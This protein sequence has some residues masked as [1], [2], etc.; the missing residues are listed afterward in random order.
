MVTLYQ[1]SADRD[2]QPLVVS[3][4]TLIRNWPREIQP[5]VVSMVTLGAEIV[6][7]QT[8]KFLQHFV[9]KGK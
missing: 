7:L 8:T 2:I 3:M 9:I 5:I 4:V 1:N 6:Q